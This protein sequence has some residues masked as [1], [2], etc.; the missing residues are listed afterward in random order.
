MKQ[1]H[2]KIVGVVILVLFTLG[3]FFEIKWFTYVGLF[4][5]VA[6]FSFEGFAIKFADL[7][8]KFGKL[9]GNFNAG[10]I[11]SV[12]FLFLLTPISFLKRLFEKKPSK[13]SNTSWV[14]VENDLVNFDKPW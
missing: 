14:E 1:E 9:L 13:D 7:W 5:G 4:I 11:L 2:Y 12:L 8:M 6:S 3:Y 10:I